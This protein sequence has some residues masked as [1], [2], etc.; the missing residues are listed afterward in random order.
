M[1]SVGIENP[2]KKTCTKNKRKLNFVI[3]ESIFKDIQ[4]K[5]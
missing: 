4:D 5:Y 2:H 3:S 1:S